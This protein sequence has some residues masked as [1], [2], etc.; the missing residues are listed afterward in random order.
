VP[1]TDDEHRIKYLPLKAIGKGLRARTVLSAINLPRL[2]PTMSGGSSLHLLA[3]S[4]RR[5]HGVAG[6]FEEKSELQKG[7]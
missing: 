6:T 4:R 1:A 5:E 3:S 7:R 2:M